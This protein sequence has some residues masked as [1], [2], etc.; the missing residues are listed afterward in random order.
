MPATLYCSACGQPLPHFPPVT[1]PS[2]GAG[3]WS[4]PKPCASGL[5]THEGRLLMVRRAH[6]PWLGHWDVPGGFC[7]TDE[8][9]IATAE[10][11]VGEETGLAIRITGILGMWMDEYGPPTAESPRKTTLNIYFHAVPAGDLHLDPDPA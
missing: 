5:V 4:D 10:R 7:G 6:Q 8:H 9:P 3:H 2:C 11:E 1:C